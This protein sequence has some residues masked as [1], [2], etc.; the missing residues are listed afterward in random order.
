MSVEQE[1][2][3]LKTRVRELED[4]NNV[5]QDAE[6]MNET[7]REY[8]NE[9]EGELTDWREWVL[10][11][12]AERKILEEL[13]ENDDK[14]IVDLSKEKKD[15]EVQLVSIDKEN[16]QLKIEKQDLQKEIFELR[17]KMERQDISAANEYQKYNFAPTGST[18]TDNNT[19]GGGNPTDDEQNGD[20]VMIGNNPTDDAQSNNQ[21][22]KPLFDN[23]SDKKLEAIWN[24]NIKLQGQVEQ[25]RGIVMQQINDT[26][27]GQASY[28]QYELMKQYLPQHS[29]D[30]DYRGIAV[31]ALL[32][33]ILY[34]AKAARDLLERFYNDPSTATLKNPAL[35]TMSHALCPLILSQENYIRAIQ[36]GYLS[37]DS[38]DTEQWKQKALK[39]ETSKFKRILE[40]YDELLTA[41]EKAGKTHELSFEIDKLAD[42]EK[43]LKAFIE[44]HFVQFSP[45]RPKKD[46]YRCSKNIV[47]Q[48]MSETHYR[49]QSLS[50]KLNQF[51]AKL[52]D[53]VHAPAQT[54]KRITSVAVDDDNK[55]DENQEESPDNIPTGD[56][57]ETIEDVLKI[58]KIGAV[59]KIFRLR[60]D[61]LAATNQILQYCQPVELGYGKEKYS[62]NLLKDANRTSIQW[63][64]LK[65]SKHISFKAVQRVGKMLE[66]I[67]EKVKVYQIPRKRV[68]NIN[69]II[70]E[71]EEQNEEGLITI[72]EKAYDIVADVRKIIGSTLY[73]TEKTTD[74]MP[75]Q[76]YEE[77]K[78]PYWENN[79]AKF[80][81]LFEKQRENQD[82]M[83]RQAENIKVSN[84]KVAEVEKAMKEK[85]QVIVI[86][87][88]QCVKEKEKST[89]LAA[90]QKENTD[91]S[92]KNEKFKTQIMNMTQKISRQEEEIA[93]KSASIEKYKK[94]IQRIKDKD[95]PIGA[96]PRDTHDANNKTLTNLPNGVMKGGAGG[97]NVRHGTLLVDREVEYSSLLQQTIQSLRRRVTELTMNRKLENCALKLK[98]LPF[99]LL[100]DKVISNLNEAV[101]K[102]VEKKKKRVKKNKPK[103]EEIV[104][105]QIDKPEA[106][107]NEDEAN[108]NKDEDNKKEEEEDE[109][110]WVTDDE[111]DSENIRQQ[112][113]AEL[114]KLKREKEMTEKM[115]TE[116]GDLS[117][118]LDNIRSQPLIIDLTKKKKR[119]DDLS[120]EIIGR[121]MQLRDVH[122]QCQQMKN[123]ITKQV[124]EQ[125][126]ESQDGTNNNNTENQ[127]EPKKN[128][129]E[130]LGSI[131][132]PNSSLK[133]LGYD[134]TH[135]VMLP[136]QSFDK[137]QTS[138]LW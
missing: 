90:I 63:G 117:L 48:H 131:E 136:S 64:K 28:V 35:S 122:I 1:V 41:I 39:F 54:T 111:D 101:N 82:K 58:L 78:Q 94:A 56:Y 26:V 87:K 5:L 72:L 16:K 53:L 10:D 44:K 130:V 33:K 29:Q 95:N 24:E 8:N 134:R 31:L 113:I 93:N 62:A 135:R 73:T 9:L 51:N 83:E 110:E 36:S 102:T 55:Y 129:G 132:I 114:M 80:R 84:T 137:L 13:H 91:L 106:K 118:S 11:V 97:A 38:E 99:T 4:Q 65:A 34:K 79:A 43:V 121:Q 14:H 88:E 124:E 50:I 18:G 57:E 7:L 67:N 2:L 133:S 17:N 61:V 15:L 59:E 27:A 47:L 68:T 19:A 22:D 120:Q 115:Q 71:E 40:S 100:R 3:G 21:Q 6:R 70:E 20:Y 76:T 103:K 116:L 119:N 75:S 81:V 105:E 69:K 45:D 109:Y 98:P 96:K 85:E 30:V 108:E 112:K 42:H 128:L 125:N 37:I 123:Q 107:N 49:F 12:E 138:F 127:P 23:S 89:N 52:F 60:N 86:L 25:M 126:R 104:K 77:F 66:A 92:A 46:E 74:D 32:Q